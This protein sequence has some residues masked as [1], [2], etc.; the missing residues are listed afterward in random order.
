MEEELV[1]Q[2]EL[3]SALE[4]ENES[5]ASQVN[6]LKQENL[7]STTLGPSENLNGTTGAAK[8]P[9]AYKLASSAPAPRLYCDICDQF[10]LHD[11]DE[12]PKQESTA[13][14]KLEE[15]TSHTKLN[16]PKSS[17]NR[18]YCDL[19]EEFGHEESECTRAG[20]QAGL[21]LDQSASD[22]EF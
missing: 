4:S 9:S 16:I 14:E 19:C 2:K 3:A 12:C 11:T 20:G 8:L 15:E 10:D 5:L 22:E 17:S 7:L 6:Q 1:K 21:K 18:A 13:Q